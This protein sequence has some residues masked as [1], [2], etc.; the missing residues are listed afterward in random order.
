[1]VHN[2]RIEAVLP[3]LTVDIVTARALAPLPRLIEFS[4]IA[5]DRG[6][7]GLFPKGRA[8][9]LGLDLS[10]LGVDCRLLPSRTSSDGGIVRVAAAP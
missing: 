3:A 2:G 9:L 10:R 5:L 4:K 6:S 1:M 8:E 7:V